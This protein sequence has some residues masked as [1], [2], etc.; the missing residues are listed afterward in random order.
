MFAV[1]VKSLS[2]MDFE[3]K[4]DVLVVCASLVLRGVLQNDHE[5]SLPLC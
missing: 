2:E 5:L 1:F 3:E 4:V